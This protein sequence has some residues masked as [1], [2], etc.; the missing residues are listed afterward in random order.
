MERYGGD[1]G[2]AAYGGTDI[3]VLGAVTI[4]DSKLQSWDVDVRDLTAASIL[5]G[6]TT[7]RRFMQRLEGV[8]LGECRVFVITNAGASSPPSLEATD[9]EVEVELVGDTLVGEVEH[10]K[11]AAPYGD[12]YAFIHIIAPP[13]VQLPA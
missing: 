1:G 4:N 3:P 11:I 5:D 6:L 2:N 9:E 12:A 8:D 7:Q 10:L 13:G